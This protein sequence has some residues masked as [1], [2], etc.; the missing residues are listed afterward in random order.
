M[1]SL[2]LSK[3]LRVGEGRMVK[4][5]KHIA[6]HVESLS[7]EVEGLTDEQL[8]AKTV[9]FRERYAAG[10]T[11]DELLPEAFAVAREASWRVI[12]QKHFH[13]QI[14]G[15]AALH[16][17]NVAE[18]KTGEGKTLTCV[19]PAYLNAIAGDGVHVVTV[20]DYLAKRDSEWMGRVHRSLGL[21]T[22]VILSGMTPAERR[23]AYACDITYGTNNEFGFDYL[24]DNMTHSLDDLVQRGHAFAIVDEVDS[25]LID[26]ARTPLIISGP[27]D[28]SSKWYSEF[29]RIAPLLKK[30]VHYE[31]DIRKRTIGVHEAGVELVEDQLGIDNL[32]E[33][34]NSPLV[35]YLNNAIKAKELY[36]KDK[37]YIVRDG[38]VIIVDEFTG[39]VLVG[40]RYNEG[41]HQAIEAKEKV[42]IKAENQTLA[43]ITLQNY[44]RL[45]EKLSGMTGTAET[46]AAELH[47]TYTLGVI[48]IPTNRPMI[49][50][51]NGD[52]IYKT[53]EAKFD[54]V[55]D[56]VVE[57]HE[58]GQ[59]VLIGT[60]SVERSEY[61]SKQF[62]KRGVAHNVLNAKF[63]EKEATIIAEAGRSGAVTVATNM[64][65][66]G[67]DVVLG[68]NPDIIADIAL[69]SQGLDPVTTPEEY[70]AAWDEI[71]IKVKTDVKEDAEKVRAAGGLYV[72]GTERHESRRIDNQLRGRSGRQGDPGESRFY[73]SLGDEL[74]RRFNGSALESIMTRLNLPDDV[75]IEAKMVSK[76]IKSAQTQVEQQNFEIRKNVL[77]YDEVM[78]QQRTVIYKERRQILEGEDMEGQ[79]EQMIT[80]VITAYVDGATAEGY[81]EDWDL[82]QLW[83]ALKT[84]YPVGIDH[85]KLAGEDGAGINSDL[86]RDDLRTALLEDAH[87]AYKKREAE[88]DAIAGENGMRELERRVFLSVLDR[89]WREH[90]YEMDYLKEGIG[91]RAMAQRDPLVEYQREGYDMFIGM[92]DGLKEE[93]VGFLFN[94]QV[95]A[96]PA[97]PS[98]GISVTAG[99][100]AAASATAP[101]PL[102]TQENAAGSHGTAAPS[103]LRAKGLDDTGPSRL[104]YS[105]PDEDGKAK[106]TRDAAD[107]S[108]DAASRRE[109]RE[110]ARTQSKS[111]KAPKSK[112]KR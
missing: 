62:T 30:D 90:L 63:H 24:R 3:L 46:E 8:K 57:R 12:D 58:N 94:L 49:R 27:A 72:L 51:D 73:L 55:V 103:A 53:E 110:A 23:V 29:A 2:S 39:R 37:D 91:L 84:L 35:S 101:K 11:L 97:Q 65:G 10:E 77:K 28:G 82:E 92:L 96:A 34:A 78:N 112:R 83:T 70:E 20:N 40:R 1:P 16:F 32:Y 4:R 89:K 33:A 87:A 60:T 17:G 26:E 98:T 69:R 15:G 9:E 25:I 50:V 95:E 111:T 22:S 38:E 76:A 59:P 61:L 108:G 36:N 68:G 6:D 107:D 106:A 7:P 86:S 71:L 47:Q 75:P 42:E 19:L 48:P 93:S 74:M 31:V 41:M 85:K 45:Y 64:A 67:T 79:V 105:G 21:E 52:L 102:P 13:V 43:T 44:F 100:A 66:R 5:L 18:M 109:R 56:D 99:S 54:A 14:M 88:I 80:D 104:T 81:V